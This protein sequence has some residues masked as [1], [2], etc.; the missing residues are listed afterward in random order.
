M[1]VEGWG[2]LITDVTEELPCLKSEVE[3]VQDRGV[4]RV[5]EGNSALIG[6]KLLGFCCCF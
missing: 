1:H 5:C 6:W 2:G 3:G 4:W